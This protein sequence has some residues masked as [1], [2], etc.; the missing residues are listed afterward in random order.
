MTTDAHTAESIATRDW[1]KATL[2]HL[3]ALAG[4]AGIPFGNVLGPLI[5]WLCLR[6]KHAEVNEHGKESLNFQ[7]SMTLYALIAGLSIF[8]LIGIVLLPI[9]LL[10]DLILL[11]I[12]SVKASKG[13][14]YRYP[15]TIRF[16]S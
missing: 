16:L 9:V 14:F 5:F 6:D 8:V 11:I 2:C 4:F 1:S 15:L 13:E 12:A 7:L 3:L 10:L